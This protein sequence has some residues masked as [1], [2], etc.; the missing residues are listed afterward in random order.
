MTHGGA[1]QIGVMAAPGIPEML[2]T[3]R[4]HPLLADHLIPALNATPDAFA[5]EDLDEFVRTYA[6][7]G[8]FGGAA[9]LYRSMLSEG[10]EI[11]KLAAGK[12]SMPV[13]AVGGFSEEFT[14]TTLRHVATDVT[15]VVLDGVGHYVA[16][17]APDRL[18]DTLLA[19]YRKT[20]SA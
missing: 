9:G 7:P 18:A 3:G 14:A 11:R 13:L 15:P 12:L 16:M 17:E 10:D 20:E 6:R 1:W 4:E 2:L 19:F 5:P 8:G